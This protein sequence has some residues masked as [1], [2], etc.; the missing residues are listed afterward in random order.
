MFILKNSAFGKKMP[1]GNSDA[2]FL[3]LALVK[4]FTLRTR[5][6]CESDPCFHDRFMDACLQPCSTGRGSK[7]PKRPW[8]HHHHNLSPEGFEK[9]RF[10]RL[11]LIAISAI[12]VWG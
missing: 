6:N 4:F 3:F 12:P 2:F 5:W 11:S 1:E 10:L 9:S 8:L 7:D